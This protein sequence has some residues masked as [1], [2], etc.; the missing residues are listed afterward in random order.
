MSRSWLPLVLWLSGCV[1]VPQTT[2]VYDEQFRISAQ[3]MELQSAQIGS[4]ESC[5]NEGCVAILVGAGAV[6]AAS[7]VVSGSLV[8]AGNVVYWF[9]KQG[10]CE[11]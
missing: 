5:R 2:T 1:F 8:V 11:R 6:A 10:K 4:L 9:E 3:H 7:A